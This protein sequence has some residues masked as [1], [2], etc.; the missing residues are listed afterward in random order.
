MR[1]YASAGAV[2]VSPDPAR[3]FTLLLEQVRSSGERQVVAPK[4]RIEANE[5][6]LLAAIREVGEEAGLHRVRYVAHLGQQPYQ[7]TDHDQVAAIK[8][9]DWFLFA[10]DDT[11][12]AVSEAEGFRAARWLPLDEAMDAASHV[13]FRPYLERARDL[14]AWRRDA[15]LRYDDA[16]TEPVLQISAKAAALLARYPGVGLGLT[17]SAARG[18][19]IPNWSNLDLIAWGAASGSV[20]GRALTAAVSAAADVAGVEVSLCFPFTGELDAASDGLVD[21][22]VNAA[23]CCRGIDLATLAGD[24]AHSPTA[25]GVDLATAI[26]RLRDVAQR[27]ASEPVQPIVTDARRSLSLLSTAGRLI[28]LALDPTSDL[29]L[30]SVVAALSLR[31]PAS[32]AHQLL[33]AYDRWRRDG[34]RDTNQVEELAHAVPEALDELLSLI[35]SGEFP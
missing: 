26:A 23:L 10:A 14:I 35:A 21:M 30:S 18:D 1:T 34:K 2:V 6:P 31:M 7:F 25:S 24:S 8:T 20:A 15:C 5:S 12:V 32:T 3:P 4:G 29:R 19:F 27:T 17:G 11:A 22:K 16:P 13:G 28:A 9:V 33:A